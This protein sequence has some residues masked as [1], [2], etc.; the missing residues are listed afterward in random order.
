MIKDRAQKASALR[1]IVAKRWFPQLEI[2]VLP[3]IAT[4]TKNKLITDIDVLGSVP[5]EFLGYRAF[6]FDCKS[7]QRESPINRTLWLR[8]LMD[9]VHAARG[10]LICRS[11][12]DIERDHR[13]SAAE[14]D[15]SIVKEGEFGILANATDGHLQVGVSSVA[16]LIGKYFFLYRTD[17][18]NWK[19]WLS[20][21][22]QL[23]GSVNHRQKPV[24]K[25]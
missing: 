14:L 11:Q 17:F 7:G 23:F 4:T 8:G 15:I 9:R 6:L 1:Y 10:L 21:H 13:I 16:E 3:K 22:V 20:F 5:D 24:E 25:Q 19:I 18:Q 2:D 12:K